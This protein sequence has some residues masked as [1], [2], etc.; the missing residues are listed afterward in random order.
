MNITIPDSV[1]EIGFYAFGGC[2]SLTNITIPDSVTRI[3]E[4]AFEGCTYL[5]K[6]KA[7]PENKF[8]II[9]DN[10]LYTKDKKKLV[11]CL[12]RTHFE[13]PNGVTEI[14]DYAFECCTSLANINIPNGVT[15]IGTAAFK[16]CTSLADISIPDSVER[17]YDGV[18]SDCSALNNIKVS[19][20][21]NYFITD[22]NV[23]YTK[24]KTTL[25][26]C[27]NRTCFEIP[28]QATRISSYAFSDCN[29][30]AEIKI[31]ESMERIEDFA[32]SRCTSLTEI[33]IPKRVCH[34][35]YGIFSLCSALNKIIVSLYNKYLT[36]ENNVLYIKNKRKLLRCTNRTC[37]E[38]PNHVTDIDSYAFSGC[39]LLTNITIPNSVNYIGNN[40]FEGC[41]ALKTVIASRATFNKFRRRF[42]S[43]VQW[44]ELKP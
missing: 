13:I 29:L 24:D 7:S 23:L 42:P 3:S 9:E 40:V 15:E 11:L 19:P 14:S 16:G 34:T 33:K 31:P 21:N 37:F 41:T 17:I 18:F 43:N 2:T 27:T 39:N 35:G 6:I 4:S 25:I 26:H 20:H 32:F 36:A 22:D 44:Q 30:L 28:N 1:T 10:V 12:N 38:I 8:F 5:Q